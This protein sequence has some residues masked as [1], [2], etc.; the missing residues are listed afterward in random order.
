M[1]MDKMMR[2]VDASHALNKTLA[3]ALR[4]IDRRALNALVLVKRH[5]NALAG[6]GVVAQAFRE[7]AASLKELAKDMQHHVSPLILLQMRA[8]MHKRVA[9]SFFHVENLMG[10]KS[11]SSL[12]SKRQEW[13]TAVAD[14]ELEARVLFQQLLA[15]VDRIQAG[16]AEQE[17]VVVNGRIEAALSE[18]TGAPLSRVSRDMGGAVDIVSQAIRNYRRQLEESFNEISTRI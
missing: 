13:L 4:E 5:G 14:E 18:G 2:L 1:D 16:I 17:Y 12:S 10:D 6:Y 8:L 9:D 15:A 3:S 7:R 11:C